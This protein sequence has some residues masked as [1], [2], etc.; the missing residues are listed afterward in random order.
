MGDMQRAN[1]HQGSIFRIYTSVAIVL[2]SENNSIPIK[3]VLN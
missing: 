1:A 2:E 3:V